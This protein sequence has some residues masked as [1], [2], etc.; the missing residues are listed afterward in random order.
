MPGVPPTGVWLGASHTLGRPVPV[1]EPYPHICRRTVAGAVTGQ[2]V[3]LRWKDCAACQDESA[4]G[5]PT[6]TP[7]EES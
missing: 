1:G 6:I 7:L 4:D 2:P 3:R 5:A